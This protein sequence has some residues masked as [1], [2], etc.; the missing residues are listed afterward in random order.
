VQRYSSNRAD[1]VTI[2]EYFNYRL[3][4]KQQDNFNLKVDGFDYCLE[5]KGGYGEDFFDNYL[6]R[7]GS[8]NRTEKE[9]VYNEIYHAIFDAEKEE[10]LVYYGSL[11]EIA[12]NQ[13]GFLL[14]AFFLVS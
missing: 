11:N 4:Y 3:K 6:M 5:L 2:P 8:N 13:D 1:K 9:T 7:N 12:K 10:L 14:E